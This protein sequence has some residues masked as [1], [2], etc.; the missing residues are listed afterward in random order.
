MATKKPTAK[1]ATKPKAAKR[2]PSAAFMKP[3]NIGE[4][5]QPEW[6][7]KLFPAQ[8]WLR[9]FGLTSRRTIC[10]TRKK[11]ATS[12]QMRISKKFLAERKPSLCL[13]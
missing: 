7:Q 9:N 10:R 12:M 2:K 11:D 4:A 13:R 1:K 6:E 8:K 3:M 5:L